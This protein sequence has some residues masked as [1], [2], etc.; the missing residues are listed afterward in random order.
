[1]KDEQYSQSL[2]SCD[3]WSIY[4]ALGES[5]SGSISAG[6]GGVSLSDRPEHS[7]P[8]PSWSVYHEPRRTLRLA[9]CALQRYKAQR[10]APESLEGINSK[11][12]TR[13]RWRPFASCISSSSLREPLQVRNICFLIMYLCPVKLP[14]HF[15]TE[16]QHFFQGRDQPRCSQR[17]KCLRYIAQL[18]LRPNTWGSPDFMWEPESYSR[19]GS[20]T[21]GKH[22][23]S[24]NLNGNYVTH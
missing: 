17:C 2:E 7:H 22:N 6:E 11:P 23:P 1:M 18:C 5:V 14:S 16:P 10:T 19:D 21:R 4:G 24:V 8:G 15:H 3:L 13:G 12:Y 9:L 20:G